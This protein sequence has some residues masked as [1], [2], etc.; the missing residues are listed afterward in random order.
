MG[1]RK[2]EIEPL[3]DDRNR[4]VTF[5]KRKAG[6]FK[7]AYEL[8]VLCQVDLA[9]IIVGNNDK[10]YEFSSVDTNELLNKYLRVKAHELKLPENYGKYK[11]KLHLLSGSGAA[12]EDDLQD[13]PVDDANAD[14]DYESETPEPKRKKTGASGLSIYSKKPVSSRFATMSQH[15]HG[16]QEDLQTQR[17]VLRVQI[18]SDVKTEDDSAKTI[19]ALDTI[20]T[21]KHKLG[22]PPDGDHQAPQ[23][24]AANAA[25]YAFSKFKSPED[26]KIPQLPLPISQ[27]LSPILTTAPQLPSGMPFFLLLHNPLPQGQYPPAI[28]PT[29]VFNQVFNQWLGGGSGGVNVG[30]PNAVPH[31]GATSTTAQ[32]ANSEGNVIPPSG[33][34]GGSGPSSAGASGPTGL[35]GSS[36][37]SVPHGPLGAAGTT[38]AGVAG[39]AGGSGGGAEDEPPKFRTPLLQLNGDQTPMSAL[40]SRYMNDIFPSPSNL[41]PPQEWPTGM[42]PYTSSMPHYF[43]G[44]A[45]SA[46]GATPLPVNM[47]ANARLT[48]QGQQRLQFQPHG[49][50]GTQSQGQGPEYGQF[51]K[52]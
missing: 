50:G 23:L 31:P 2:I 25:R 52:R 34:G 6:L 26:K 14:S 18:P 45:P 22:A 1:R 47:Y 15:A 7:K 51:Y 27:L 38:T 4:T 5:V 49:L 8:A 37:R 24:N 39:V 30:P 16:A 40:P 41:Y 44:M 3:T 19:T 13:I 32:G 28:L 10:V 46:S 33:A 43:V 9:V 21:G 36:A 11:K 29:P 12:I 20:N 48:L 17:P 42:T 35:T